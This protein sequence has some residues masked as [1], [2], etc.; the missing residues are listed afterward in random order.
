[1]SVSEPNLTGRG[2]GGGGREPNRADEPQG[3]L[4]TFAALAMRRNPT[5]PSQ[6]P[7]NNIQQSN[8]PTSH[9]FPRFTNMYIGFFFLMTL[10]LSILTCISNSLLFIFR[11]P[12]TVSSLVRLALST[13]FPGGLLS[14]AQSYPSLSS[15]PPGAPGAP[16]AAPAVSGCLGQAL[17]MSLTSTSSDSEQVR[18]FVSII[19]PIYACFLNIID[20]IFL[21]VLRCL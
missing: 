13:N 3:L 4:E 9:F 20:K 19:K 7:T 6:Q 17:T 10:I 16:S 1:M 5:N 11:G 2:G 8:N 21:F 15:G 12:N 18:I 14:A